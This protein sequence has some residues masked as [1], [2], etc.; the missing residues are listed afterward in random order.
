MLVR[1]PFRLKVA[2]CKPAQA[3]IFN[4]KLA[5]KKSRELLFCYA[6]VACLSISAVIVR[7][8][9]NYSDL[10]VSKLHFIDSSISS[11]M[12]VTAFFIFALSMR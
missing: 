10:S 1:R 7:F 12:I 3:G 11:R 6:R 5:D 2:V 9:I 8:S 4:T